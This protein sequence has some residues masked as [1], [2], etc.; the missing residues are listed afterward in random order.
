M[1]EGTLA[2]L[3]SPVKRHSYCAYYD[4]DILASFKVSFP[5]HSTPTYFET[6]FFCL[7][8]SFNLNISLITKADSIRF[9]SFYLV[10]YLASVIVE[11]VD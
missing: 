5:P 10:D 6:N 8:L 7:I 3:N 1:T 9:D 2:K 11:N 4:I